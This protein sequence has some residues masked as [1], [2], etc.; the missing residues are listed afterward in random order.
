MKKKFFW[1]VLLISAATVLSLIFSLP[2]TR[3]FSSMPEW[4]KKHMPSEGMI[5]G[6]DLQGGVHLV[7]EVEGD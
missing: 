4:W 5:L 2:S 7:Y 1:R 3:L 6:L